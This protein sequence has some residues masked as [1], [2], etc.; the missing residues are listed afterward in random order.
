MWDTHNN[1]SLDIRNA[2]VFAARNATL[3][4]SHTFEAGVAAAGGRRPFV[5]FAAGTVSVTCYD[6]LRKQVYM[7]NL[8]LYMGMIA[9]SIPVVLITTGIWYYQYTHTPPWWV[10]F[11]ALRISFTVM[12]FR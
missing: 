6:V 9:K 8:D 11:T 3:D 4:S 1:S 12:F 5:S 7:G 2:T 10:M